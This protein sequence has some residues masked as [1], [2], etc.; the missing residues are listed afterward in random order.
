MRLI[1]GLYNI[2]SDFSGC[3]ATIGNFDGVHL[4]HQAILQ[5]LKKQ[6]AEHQLPT[7]VMMFEPQPR[8]FFAPDQAPARLANM[9]EKL[10]DLASFGV[11]YVLCLPFNQ[12]LRSMSADQFIQTILLDGLRI[13]H[14]IVGDDFRFGCDRTGD[15]QLLQK[16]GQESG[17]SV[18]DTKTFEVEGKRVS[19]TRIRD[20][21]S[22]NDLDAVN[23]LLGRPY[24]MSGRIGYGRQLG[25][26][27][28]VPTANVILQRNKLPMTG[29]YAVKAIEIEVAG[30]NESQV[31]D[32]SGNVKVWQGV[33]NIGVKPTVAGT[34]E[35][36]LEVHIF[37]FSDDVYGKR[38]S[39]EFCQKIR[40]EQ[41]FNGL[42][43]LKAAI[44]NDM[45]V[46][47][48]FFNN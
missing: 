33:A 32:H 19:S 31:L 45:K 8:E 5:Q 1:R 34:P 30:C 12:K 22:A 47:R 9:S 3:V 18:E 48:D 41:K 44:S 46:A 11:D 36:S 16:A 17:F 24:R 23:K 38:L 7:V 43:E 10:Q 15:Y 21:L 40:E 26:T 2:P 27:I 35:P 29:V 39:I 25:R 14:L 28:G 42:D 13:R 4:G 37:D 6:G 20:C